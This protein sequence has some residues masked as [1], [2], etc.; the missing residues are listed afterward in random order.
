VV[1]VAHQRVERDRGHVWLARDLHGLPQ[2]AAEPARDSAH[3]RRI[4]EPHRRSRHTGAVACGHDADQA[5]TA[6][7]PGSLLPQGA[8]RWPGLG[9]RGGGL[10]RPR[11]RD[12]GDVA[13]VRGARHHCHLAH[14]LAVLLR[15]LPRLQP[16][17]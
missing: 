11:R 4:H 8:A 9:A 13:L 12:A 3:G 14:A 2:L 7:A 5:R 6:S 15:L 16:R 17:E 10:G 1:L